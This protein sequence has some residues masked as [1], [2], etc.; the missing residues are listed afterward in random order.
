MERTGE[1]W[2]KRAPPRPVQSRILR[3]LSMI[4]AG[5]ESIETKLSTVA[6]DYVSPSYCFDDFMSDSE[7]DALEAQIAG[8]LVDCRV[9]EEGSPFEVAALQ[10]TLERT[11]RLSLRFNDLQRI[12]SHRD[13]K[14][15]H[16]PTFHGP[17]GTKRPPEK[18]EEK[19]KPKEPPRQM[20]VQLQKE[21]ELLAAETDGELDAAKRVEVRMQQISQLLSTFSS[22][23][24]E[25]QETIAHLFDVTEETADVVDRGGDQLQRAAQRPSSLPL[26]FNSIVLAAAFALLLLHWLRP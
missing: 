14:R 15:R 21:R 7:R 24:T 16:A 17:W 8:F 3:K 9:V 23:V 25:Q 20:Q 19:E 2:P 4:M 18:P 10:V 12:R 22:L 13:L 5:V 1:F 26:V 11:K 6:S